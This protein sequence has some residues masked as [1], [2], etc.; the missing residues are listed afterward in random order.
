MLFAIVCCIPCKDY[1]QSHS[2]TFSQDKYLC[3]FV[4]DMNIKWNVYKMKCVNERDQCCCTHHN[5]Y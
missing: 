3:L 2:I 5:E 1:Q 4:F